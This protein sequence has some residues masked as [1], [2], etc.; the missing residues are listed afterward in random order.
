LAKDLW[1]RAQ[2]ALTVARHDLALDADAAASRAYYAAFYAVS[3][4]L[5]E[6]GVTP[7]K[8]SAVEAAVHRD[9]VKTGLWT[10]ELGEAYTRL[11]QLRTRG[12]Y[13]GGDHVSASAAEEAI[14]AAAAIID[15]VRPLLPGEPHC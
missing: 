1:E 6:K 10:R 2:K 8:H 3:T 9:L 15:A 14:R 4:C 11:V 7:S 12:D 5:A 13:G